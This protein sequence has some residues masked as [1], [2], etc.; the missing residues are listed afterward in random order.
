[1]FMIARVKWAKNHVP[2]VSRSKHK[3]ITVLNVKVIQ[4]N[5]DSLGLGFGGTRI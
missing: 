5:D 1:M 4:N 2:V 3:L